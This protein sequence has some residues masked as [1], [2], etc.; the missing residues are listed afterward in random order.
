MFRKALDNN[1]NYDN[2]KG[3][4]KGILLPFLLK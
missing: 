2:E 3:I 1:L 4:A